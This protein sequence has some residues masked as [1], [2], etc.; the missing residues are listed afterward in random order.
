MQNK[1]DSQ[2]KPTNFIP[3]SPVET[4]R[5]HIDT[6]HSVLT[7]SSIPSEEKEIF[8][9]GKNQNPN[10]YNSYQFQNQYQYQTPQNQNY[11][12]NPPQNFYNQ[13]VLPLNYYPQ[14]QFPVYHPNPRVMSYND[15]RYN[16]VN[17][18]FCVKNNYR[19]GLR[20]NYSLEPSNHFLRNEYYNREREIRQN[21]KQAYFGPVSNHEKELNI[22]KEIIH[23]MKDKEIR[24]QRKISKRKKIKKNKNFNFKNRKKQEV[25]LGSTIFCLEKGDW[26]CPVEN[27][28]NWNYSKRQ[29]CNMCN[30]PKKSVIEKNF[31]PLKEKKILEEN[32]KD[33]KCV[34]CCYINSDFKDQC[35]R[36]SENKP[37]LENENEKDFEKKTNGFFENL[38]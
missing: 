13:R 15:P 11:I 17:R 3:Y 5:K 25:K 1:K 9:F 14:Q 37:C 22:L 8:N 31:V 18:N 26:K 12:Q 24:S 7:N 6:N 34:K 35:Y 28:K 23:I 29:K 33:W 32:K 19:N 4:H 2:T 27:C 30:H 20:N 36:C 10:F 21:V 16:N 38:K